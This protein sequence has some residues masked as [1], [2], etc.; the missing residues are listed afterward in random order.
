MADEKKVIGWVTGRKR[1][2]M[3]EAHKRAL[4]AA[5]RGIPKSKAHRKRIGKG[6]RRSRESWSDEQWA[7]YRAALSVGQK[8]RRAREARERDGH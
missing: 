2:P 3:S 6:V 8:R 1:G 4:S 5:K 7:A